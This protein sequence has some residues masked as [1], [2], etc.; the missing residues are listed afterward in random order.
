MA[1]KLRTARISLNRSYQGSHGCIVTL[2]G[3]GREQPTPSTTIEFTTLDEMKSK[4]TA[5]A[6]SQP[7]GWATYVK[8]SDGGRKPPGYDAATNSVRFHNL[9]PEPKQAVA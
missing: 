1:R 7:G 5:F 6:N 9:E 4:V 3:I 8:L 2:Y